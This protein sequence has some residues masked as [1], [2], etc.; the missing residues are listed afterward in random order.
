MMRAFFAVVLLLAVGPG[1]LWG[2]ESDPFGGAN[3]PFGAPAGK[4]NQ[5]AQNPAQAPAAQAA[6][7]TPTDPLVQAV[8]GNDPRSL[9]ETALTIERAIRIG[10][11]DLAVPHI[12]RLTGRQWDPLSAA[13]FLSHVDRGLLVRA[14]A[15][16]QLT[17]E[18]R[19]AVT[20]LLTATGKA[21][22]DA[23][24]LE[25]LVPDLQATEPGRVLAARRGIAQGG[26]AG[27]A[28]LVNE[29]IADQPRVSPRVLEGEIQRAGRDAIAALRAA[30]EPG[31]SEGTRLAA[32][33]ALG[34]WQ[35][36]AASI[37]LLEAALNPSSPQAVR[38]SAQ[39]GLQGWLGKIPSAT[40]AAELLMQEVDRNLD[41]LQDPV[42]G[43]E[44]SSAWYLDPVS[45]RLALREVTPAM[46]IA[47]EA[48]RA[49]AA[50]RDVGG[51]PAQ[52][53][54]ALAG[55][56]VYHHLLAEADDTGIEEPDWDSLQSAWEDRGGISE[57]LVGKVLQQALDQKDAA[58]ASAAA[59]LL[60]SIGT[61]ESVRSKGAA[62]T[63]LVRAATSG[64]P[65]ARFAAAQ[66][67]ARISP[68][69]AYAGSSGVI[70]T[71]LEMAQLEELPSAI[72]M[73]RDRL[74]GERIGGWLRD[75]GFRTTV[76]GTCRQ[77]L[78]AVHTD[79]DLGLVIMPSQPAGCGLAELVDRLRAHPHGQAVPIV[80]VGDDPLVIGEVLSRWRGPSR[81]VPTLES[82]EGLTQAWNDLRTSLANPPLST[83]NRQQ[84]RH[85]GQQALAVVASDPR[86]TA[87]YRLPQYEAEL[88]QVLRKSGFTKE[89]FQVWSAL[90]TTQ[91]QRML[92][93][94]AFN[95]RLEPIVRQQAAQ[96]FAQSIARFG[97]RLDRA[98]VQRQYDRF[99]ATEDA[100]TQAALSLVLDALETRAV[101]RPVR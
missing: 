50:L 30:A 65:R 15:S 36:K 79:S 53:E 58:L 14:A 89:S 81:I 19:T 87:L 57:E 13:D 83:V 101:G 92:A 88:G 18:Q 61:A 96:A 66:A 55:E 21:L 68:T 5:S 2:Q 23:Q 100:G 41:R 8:L 73:G 95:P 22:A 67:V 91:S 72:V 7:D 49:A 64:P 33:N 82:L 94:I 31:G 99:N 60:G 43:G 17:A 10:R 63:P 27:L 90:G 54:R 46:G 77:L 1:W 25:Q 74:Y 4:P 59:E 32:L 39:R 24:Y 51:T 35:P 34:R 98:D 12:Q 56:L 93:D 78:A 62:A 44:L 69:D 28:A 11:P 85:G 48:A 9:R 80:V 40:E 52:L 47:R 26:L 86:L 97:T 75:F 42:D 71:W 45:H 3:D 84:F 70:A 6:Q 76:A 20:D 37:E 38:E 29:L 16:E